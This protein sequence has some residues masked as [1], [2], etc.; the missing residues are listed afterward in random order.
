MLECLLSPQIS[1]QF[2]A[3]SLSSLSYVFSGNIYPPTLH[4]KLVILFLSS[5]P[6]WT[7]DYKGRL[8]PQLSAWTFSDL[9]VMPED[10]TAST[11]LHGDLSVTSSIPL[12]DTHAENIAFSNCTRLESNTNW[13]SAPGTVQHY[14]KNNKQFLIGPKSTLCGSYI[15]E[16]TTIQLFFFHIQFICCFTPYDFKGK[17]VKC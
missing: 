2:S 11:T 13:P 15:R 17:S 5:T 1:C 16:E 12:L 9:S 14:T 8:C 3:I 10:S 6:L 4:L 7:T